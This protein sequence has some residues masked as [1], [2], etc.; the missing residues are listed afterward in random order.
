MKKITSYEIALSALSCAIATVLLT[1]GVYSEILLFTGY[2]FA[3]IALMLPLAKQSYKGYVLAYI[4]TCI[5]ALI[6]NAARFFDLLPF[7][8]FFGLHPLV[9]ELQL[10][11][12]INRWIACAIKALWFDGTMYLVWRFVFGMTTTVPFIDQYII[13]ILLIGGSAFFVLYDYLMY[14]W[15]FAVNV[16]VKRIHKK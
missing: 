14:K 12:K 8:M 13:P 5:L 16:L 7:I 1:V 11:T 10:K 6:F 2:L 9:N 4:A 15:R 3:C